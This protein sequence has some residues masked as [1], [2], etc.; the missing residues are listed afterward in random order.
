MPPLSAPVTHATGP[1]EHSLRQRVIEKKVLLDV[2]HQFTRD[3]LHRFED[4][5][6]V[7]K[8]SHRRAGLRL[9][10]RHGPGMPAG[11]RSTHLSATRHQMDSV[12]FRNLVEILTQTSGENLASD[13]AGDRVMYFVEPGVA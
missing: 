7:V 8:L 10:S 11:S 4:A 1:R 5:F 9:E 2:V 13:G 6:Q 3:V 12:I